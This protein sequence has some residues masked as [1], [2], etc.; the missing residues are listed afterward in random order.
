MSKM[1]TQE[2]LKASLQLNLRLVSKIGILFSREE[3]G[4][5]RSEVIQFLGN[6]V[7]R[8]EITADDLKKILDEMAQGSY[9]PITDGLLDGGR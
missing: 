1:T 7:E 3:R 8:G 2:L 4:N 6:V 5:I 9:D